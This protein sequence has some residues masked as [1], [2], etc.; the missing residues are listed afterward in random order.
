MLF[1]IVAAIL[2]G[3]E[4]DF[5]DFPTNKLCMYPTVKRSE[6]Q[7]KNAYNILNLLA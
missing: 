2:H 6:L 3:F 1:W 5:H 4:T 7:V